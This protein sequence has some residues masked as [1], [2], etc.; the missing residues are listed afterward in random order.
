MVEVDQAIIFL[1][2]VLLFLLILW[3]LQYQRQKKALSELNQTVSELEEDVIAQK[4]LID[5]QMQDL[6]AQ[7]VSHATLNERV[8]HAEKDAENLA[9]HVSQKEQTIHALN[10]EISNQKSEISKL[11]TR[12]TEERK[13]SIE[14]LQ[15]LDDAKE[16]LG[17]E[18]KVLA[19]QIFEEKGKAL[20][21]QSR[22]SLDAVL[23]PMQEQFKAFRSRVDEIHTDETKER[24]TLQAHLLQLEKLNKQMSEDALSL[25]Q[26]LKGDSKAQGNWGEMILER[27]LESSGLREGHEFVR[28]DSTTIDVG[29]RQR[30]DVIVRMPGDK[31]IIV[32]SKVSLTDYERSMA[33]K[34]SHEREK[35]IKAH[36]QSMKNHIRGLA[37]KHYA[38]LPGINSPDYV[39][40]FMPIEGAY[41]MAIEADQSIFETAFEKGVAV[42]TPST[43]YATLKLIEQ[44]WR[45]EKQSDNVLKL[46]DRASKLHDK[47]VSF[48]ESFEDV[49]M[50]LEQAKK[51]YD[52]S[53]NRMK[54]GPGN[55]IRQIDDMGKLAGKTK[56]TLPKH[57]VDGADIQ[58]QLADKD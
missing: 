41:M 32:D 53:L 46:I 55:V 1:S 13:S 7:M 57:L 36:V 39:L 31:H 45:A 27:I 48:V 56:K 52:I 25:T 47:M 30:P 5:T 33:A 8:Q 22:N 20:N 2:S 34:D 24:A 40:M 54:D 58:N 35:H 49:G 37:D 26:A 11:E 3:W 44:L 21:E 50:R 29:K 4:Q 12:L 19:N 43:L 6:T 10:L 51:S 14:K 23:K 18:F 17:N 9:A 42:V 15:F 38:H 16:K 28:E